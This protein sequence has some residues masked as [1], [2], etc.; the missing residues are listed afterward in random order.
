MRDV[1]DCAFQRQ[2]GTCEVSLRKARF[3]VSDKDLLA[4]Q[5][6]FAVRHLRS[7]HRIGNQENFCAGAH[8]EFN[9]GR[10]KMNA[11]GNHLDVQAFQRQRGARH[12]RR[13]VV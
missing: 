12:T 2:R 11:V 4:A 1:A 6:V 10:M 3:A 13:T 9:R 5:T 8:G 7:L